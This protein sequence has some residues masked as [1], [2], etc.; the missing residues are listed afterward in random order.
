MS[1][2]EWNREYGIW[3]IKTKLVFL[4]TDIET[5]KWTSFI[6]PL[7]FTKHIRYFYAK[8]IF[9]T[10]TRGKQ[11]KQLPPRL[12]KLVNCMSRQMCKKSLRCKSAPIN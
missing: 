7:H 11:T 8:I 4:L 2:S 1:S 5:L 3:W 10:P 12:L 6:Q 9:R